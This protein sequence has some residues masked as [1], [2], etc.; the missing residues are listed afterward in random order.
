MS[1]LWTQN[2]KERRRSSLHS[3]GLGTDDK[4]FSKER[5]KDGGHVSMCCALGLQEIKKEKEA[6]S[7]KTL[8]GYTT[9]PTPFRAS[10]IVRQ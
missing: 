1:E 10:A 3:E 7:P 6:T 9:L 8:T 5:D 4:V 2:N